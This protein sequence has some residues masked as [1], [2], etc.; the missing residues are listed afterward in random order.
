M[1]TIWLRSTRPR[2][3]SF[4]EPAGDPEQLVGDIDDGPSV[5]R[6]GVDAA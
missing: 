1:V 6:D 4:P 3:P 5:G 2:P